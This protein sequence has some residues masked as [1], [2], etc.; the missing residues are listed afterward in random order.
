MLR[1]YYNKQYKYTNRK[2]VDIS[3]DAEYR[4]IDYENIDSPDTINGHIIYTLVA[5]EEVP[6]YIQDLD[7]GKRWY[8][9]GITQ[10]RTGK[11]QISLIRDIISE[12]PELWKNEEAYIEAGVAND[13]NKYKRWNLPYT[14]TKV[15]EE[16]LNINGKSSFFVFYVNEQE[17]SNSGAISEK[18][19][20]VN[21]T[22]VPGYT[23]Y[24]FRVDNLNEINGYEYVNAGTFARVENDASISLYIYNTSVDGLYNYT[25]NLKNGT[26]K[27]SPGPARPNQ[28]FN[29]GIRIYTNDIGIENN[30][31]NCVNNL[32]TAMENFIESQHNLGSSITSSA[33][34][35]LANYVDKI[36][37]NS[38]DQ[39]FY[40]IKLN[41]TSG[42]VGTSY[43]SNATTLKSA[44]RSINWPTSGG[45]G[46]RD[47][48]NFTIQ[49]NYFHDLTTYTQYTYTLQE[50]GTATSFNFTFRADVPKLPK[51]AV[52]CVNI[53]SSGSILDSDLARMLMAAQTNGT[54]GVVTD[55]G[56][57]DTVNV[58]RIIDIQYLPF[59]VANAANE[60]IKINEV[61]QVAQFLEVDDFQYS[62]DLVDLNTINKETDTIKVVSPSRASQY[63]FRPYDN[64]GN[65][66][67]NTKI[68]I[69]PYNSVIYVRPSTQGLLLTDWDDKDCLIIAEDFSLTNVTSQ[70]TEYVYNN[71]N[72]QN[73]FERNI[74]G[75]EF[76]R[77]WERRI[78]D[79]QKKSDEW[80][81]RNLSAQKAQTYTGNL[82]II[83]GVAG[84]IG[85]AFQ[86]ENY[87]RAAQLD[88]EYNEALYQESVNIA[89]EQFSYQLDNIKSQP[90]IPSKVTT[91]DCKFLDGIYL[92][93][94]STNETEL[95]AISNY[96]K[97][98]GNRIDSYGTFEEFY[99]WFVRGKIIISNNYTQPELDELNRRLGLGIFTE[100]D[101]A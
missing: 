45:I 48:A 47:I 28:I 22:T 59:S 77:S 68:T 31:N 1:F 26:L 94:Y 53:V 4:E 52:R 63:L 60:S 5:G 24:D 98:N 50:L 18:N 43:G 13:Y 92:E 38:T 12:S 90:Q 8:V 49:N 95:D 51:S 66:K 62:T 100:V 16:R 37:Y 74:Q 96:Y 87:M 86:D 7:S 30:T 44:L 88:R 69:K 89:R 10:L 57:S 64:N 82:P 79:A 67:F 11:F 34:S 93:Y 91:I 25:Y 80:N 58:G 15:R 70:W 32:R 81:A 33:V 29:S 40:T 54:L 3:G 41:E 97:Y 85:T 19:L 42:R 99:G 23:N 6:T 39:K 101:Y 17:V 14:N 61:A 83:S 21:Q 27:R 20:V 2:I 36:I 84:A 73:A 76:E 65:M 55:H 78:E 56:I 75:R 9:S 35:N 72:F 46:S 71:R